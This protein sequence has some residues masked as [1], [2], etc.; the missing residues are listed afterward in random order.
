MIEFIFEVFGEMLLQLFAEI[1][2]QCGGQLWGSRLREQFNPWLVAAAYAVF[3]LVAGGISLLVFPHHFIN[4]AVGRLLNLVLMPIGIGVLLAVIAAWRSGGSQRSPFN[5][6]V[7]GY[8]FALS[9]AVIRYFY[10]TP[11]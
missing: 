6:F 3:G 8:L 10:T 1:L 4:A 5:R 7:C 11:G 2:V 9:M